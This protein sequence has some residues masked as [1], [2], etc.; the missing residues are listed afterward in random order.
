MLSLS[1]SGS[2]SQGLNFIKAIS[3][4]RVEA[5]NVDTID[6][7]VRNL[8]FLWVSRIKKERQMTQKLNTVGLGQS[9]F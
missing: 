1:K 3:T 2:N 6:V 9:T 8:G 7:E 5:Y 4:F